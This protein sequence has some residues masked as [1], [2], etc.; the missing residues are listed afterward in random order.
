MRFRPGRRPARRGGAAALLAFALALAPGVSPAAHTL[1]VTNH[2]NSNDV[3]GTVEWE[4]A[5]VLATRGGVVLHDAASGSFRKI[6]AAPAGLP[7]NDVTCLG[8]GPSGT[9]WA[10]TQGWGAARLK[11]GGGF[12][13][14]LTSFDGLPSD[15]VRVLYVQGDSVWVGT[16]GGIALFTE[17]PATA[18][19]S[20]RRVDTSASTAGGLA[21]DMV[22]GLAQL[23]DTLWCASGGKLSSF[24]SGVW[25]ARGAVGA[26]VRGIVVHR[27][28]LWLAT[29]A[30]PYRYAAGVFQRVAGG[31][32]G[33]SL[34][35]VSTGDALLS[36][37]STSGALRYSGGGW[38]PLGDGG[39]ELTVG[40]RGFLAS[41]GGIAWASTPSGL[42]RFDAVAD[43]WTARLS[44][45][46]G[47]DTFVPPS[48]RATVDGNGAWFTAGNNGGAVRYDGRS[49]STLNSI[50]TGGLFDVHSAFGLLSDRRGRLWFGHCCSG[51]VP[52]PR[53][54]RFDPATGAWDR[55]TAWN[56]LSLAQSPA[57]RVYAAGVEYGNGI[58]EFDED[59]GALLDSLT[60][61]NTQGGL[62]SNIIRSIAFDAAG[63]AWIALRDAGLEIWDG[64]GTA[65][66]SDDVW[67]PVTEDLPSPL[68][69]CVAVESPSRGWLGTSSGLA[70][71]EGG[72]VTRTWTLASRPALPSAQV[73]DLAL[74]AGG[75][76]WIATLSGL[77][78]LD[79]E[80]TL[81]V[82][83]T[84]EG[85]VD[86][87]VACLAWDA[88]QGALW[89]GTARGISRIV[90]G[91]GPGAG[92]SGK[93]YAYP[94]PLHPGSGPLRLGGL[95]DAIEGEIRDPAGR[96][97]R[98]F[99][100]DP[101]ADAIWDLRRTDGGPAAPG[102][103]LVVLRDGDATRILRVALLR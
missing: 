77:A 80:G 10:G 88:A 100:A 74:D 72:I 62:A 38:A 97:V 82:F 40:A 96:V 9:L 98:R 1:F 24:S 4:G 42:A 44:D 90:P 58:Y 102:V 19:A 79:R 60:P 68:T 86:D 91:G 8:I 32:A 78:R 95:T 2:I 101:T 103:Y 41:L 87:R 12:R 64:R 37:E 85:L 49:W 29:S 35:L 6:L 16:S 66:R 36:S 34:A 46:P 5:L 61:A 54:D 71:I 45:G 25:T 76:L 3:R 93:T 11:P 50:T 23:G 22:D 31:H 28:T 21:D 51:A 7:S 65:T 53:L 39:R 83:T 57:G 99:R 73:N 43:T 52:L 33:G 18:Q 26:T 20:L 27:D 67:T 81:E 48:V 56:I 89:A 14:T 69:L 75:N 63:K 55:P 59:T 30:G 15:A 84:R 47:I 17:N 92:F 13:R 94:N 70:L